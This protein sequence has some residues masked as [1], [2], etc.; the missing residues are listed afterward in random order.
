[1]ND[2]ESLKMN[3]VESLADDRIG[4]EEDSIAVR[5]TKKV[6]F[7]DGSAASLTNVVVD[8]SLVSVASWNDKLL[9]GLGSNPLDEDA[10]IDLVF[11]DGDICRSSLNERSNHGGEADPRSPLADISN[12]TKIGDD[13]PTVGKAF[14]PWM[15]VESKSRRKQNAK[16][17]Q[18]VT[19][20]YGNLEGSKFEAL[21]SMKTE[22]SKS[23]LEVPFKV[24]G[25]TKIIQGDFLKKLKGIDTRK[26]FEFVA[27][28]NLEGEI[29]GCD[30]NYGPSIIS[31][32]LRGIK[33]GQALDLNAQLAPRAN[34]LTPADSG[35]SFSTLGLQLQGPD[36]LV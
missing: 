14:G 24:L 19:I 17:G 36:V 5:N 13:Q 34:D 26:K 6:R 20:S 33:T 9:G 28:V 4:D 35:P 29:L 1:M 2:V 32:H 8:S 16:Q 25:T 30:I 22:S 18:K 3:G 15:V 21:A 11:E 12:S 27:G 7:K 10:K 23:E 31:S